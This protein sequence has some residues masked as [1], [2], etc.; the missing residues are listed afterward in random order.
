MPSIVG[1]AGSPTERSFSMRRRPFH[2]DLQAALM[3]GK[4][5]MFNST[6]SMVNSLSASKSP[7]MMAA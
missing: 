4:P 7:Q 2:P 3:D 1:F 5:Q 6:S